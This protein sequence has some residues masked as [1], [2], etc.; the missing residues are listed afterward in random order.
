[1]EH[2]I[3]PSSLSIRSIGES[4]G[5]ALRK[6]HVAGSDRHRQDGSRRQ[7]GRRSR[8]LRG[9][10]L[11]DQTIAAFNAQGIA[12]KEV[13][14]PPLWT[15]E[16]P[17]FEDHVELGFRDLIELRF[18]KAFVRAGLGLKAIRNCPGT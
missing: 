13:K 11:I 17:A 7:H 5:R 2:E 14:I 3:H 15:P 9:L 6:C 1:V 18:V 16:L 12:G 4:Q 10:S 8:R